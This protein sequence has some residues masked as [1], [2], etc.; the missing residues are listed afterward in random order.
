MVQPDAPGQVRL[1]VHLGFGLPAGQRAAPASQPEHRAPLQM[2]VALTH[3]TLVPAWQCPPARAA[4][5]MET[6]AA[7]IGPSGKRG[8][9]GEPPPCGMFPRPCSPQHNGTAQ[10]SPAHTLSACPVPRTPA[11]CLG[12][13]SSARVQ[14]LQTPRPCPNGPGLPPSTTWPSR[15]AGVEPGGPRPW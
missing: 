13:L 4:V 2:A 9:A 14:N 3:N 8:I 6:G 1:E 12:R 15:P 11:R 5:G 7:H 10:P